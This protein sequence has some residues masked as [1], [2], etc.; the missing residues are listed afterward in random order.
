MC[1]IC[2][3]LK[4]VV[5][6]LYMCFIKMCYIEFAEQKQGIKIAQKHIVCTM[7]K[8]LKKIKHVN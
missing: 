4:C 7:S 3:A 2:V 1:C 5:Y 6:V 8:Y